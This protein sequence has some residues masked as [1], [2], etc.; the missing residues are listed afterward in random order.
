VSEQKELWATSSKHRWEI[1]RLVPLAQELARK[2][3]DSGVTVGDLRLYAVHRR[4]LT[5]QE[6]GRQLS[7]L[8]GVMK[9]AGLL[10]T[11]EYRRSSI[12]KSHGNVHRVFVAP[13]E[14][15]KSA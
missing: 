12:E 2:A 9:A 4:L 5:G 11:S 1:Q 3:G 7:W 13:Q 15:R 14:T 6:R 10:P 8:G